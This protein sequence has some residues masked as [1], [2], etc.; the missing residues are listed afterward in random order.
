MSDY[1]DMERVS[2]NGVL[3]LSDAVW[4]E[5]RRRAVVISPLAQLDFVPEVAA[6]EGAKQLGLSVRTIYTLIRRYRESGGSLVALVPAHSNGGRGGKRLPEKVELILSSTISERYL[7]R[8]RTKI[9]TVVRE[10]RRRCKDE[11]LRVP[12]A[13]TIRSRIRHLRPEVAIKKREGVEAVRGLNAVPGQF[14]PVM[15]PLGVVQIDHTPVDVIVVDP[16]TREPI[17]RPWITLGIDIFSRCIVG[18]CLTLEPPSAVSVGLCLAHCVSDKRAWLE[19]MGIEAEWPVRGKPDLIHVDNGA[20]FHSEALTRG[21]EVHGIKID[22]RP[23]GEPHFGGIIERVIGTFMQMTHDLPGT[24]FSN[25]EER[26][27]YDSDRLSALTMAELEKWFALAISGPYHGSVHDG[28]GE[29]PMV[30]WKRGIM[31][32]GEPKPVRDPRSFL[33][34][35]LPVVRRCIQRQGFVIDHIGYFSNCGSP[36]DFG[37]GARAQVPDSPRPA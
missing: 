17:G 21:C 25:I 33:V 7:T 36:M 9:E 31:E 22:Y 3:T 26:G 2:E 10:V 19:R 6:A 28:I 16:F 5:A 8:Q 11:K 24:T 12:S 13:N 29:P 32:T 34:D 37:E 15:K 1:Q 14:P 18:L 20:E 35:F 23:L 27:E 30:R 4:N